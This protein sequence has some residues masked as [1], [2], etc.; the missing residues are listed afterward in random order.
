MQNFNLLAALGQI[1][2]PV[3]LKRGMSATIQEWLLAAEY[4]MSGGNYEVILCECG[5]RT[6]KRL[7]AMDHNHCI[8]S[9]LRVSWMSCGS[10]CR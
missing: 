8:P 3:L 4:I 9:N 7:S 6:L 5:I 2:K 10:L 1:R